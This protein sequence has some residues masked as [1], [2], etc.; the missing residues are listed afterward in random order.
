M[1]YSA[2]LSPNAVKTA[3][4]D[5]VVPAYNTKEH[6]HIATA[7]TEAVFHQDVATNGAV[8]WEGIKTGGLWGSRAEEQDVPNANPRVQNQK[9]F[10]VLNY[11][12]SIDIS[13]NFFDD[14]MHGAYEKAVAGFG[15]D[16]RASR[17]FHDFGLYRN[18]FG[19]TLA[20][21]GVA[22]ISNSHTNMNGDTIDNL[23]TGDLSET[24]L[25]TGIVQLFELR[26]ENGI[27]GGNV[28]EC[29]L[30]SPADFKLAVEITES[31]LRQGTSNNDLNV[32]SAK[33]GIMV[34]TSPYLGAVA[35]G[36]DDAFFLLGRNHGNYR[37]VRQGLQTTLVD[38][39]FQRNNNYIYK[40]EFREVVGAYGFD[41]IVGSA[42]A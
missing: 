21:D 32:Y 16:A 30:V 15:L 18:A 9:T 19:S 38:W 7:E 37:F 23:F 14:N 20:H 35:G 26:R 1:A 36:D 24:T 42:G 34:K 39:R 40:G 4:D 6:P 33:Y 5:I 17:D 22:L 2:G 25:N 3:L 28:G 31:E 10:S 41:A 12:Q 27:V 13:K 8:I 29:L 11:A